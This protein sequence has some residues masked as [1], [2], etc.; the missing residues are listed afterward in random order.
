MNECQSPVN[1][2]KKTILLSVHVPTILYHFINCSQQTYMHT[3]IAVLSKKSVCALESLASFTVFDFHPTIS[4][5]C[6]LNLLLH[7]NLKLN[8]KSYLKLKIT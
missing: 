1:Q 5:S 8:V 3:Y 6:S 2:K 4:L 7:F